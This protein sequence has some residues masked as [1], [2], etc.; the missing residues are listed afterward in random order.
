LAPFTIQSNLDCRL[1]KV[2]SFAVIECDGGLAPTTNCLLPLLLLLGRHQVDLVQTV[3]HPLLVL[4][5]KP[6]STPHSSRSSEPSLSMQTL[7]FRFILIFTFLSSSLLSSP[8]IIIII[9]F[10]F[11]Q[12][13]S[14]RQ[15]LH[16]S[17]WRSSFTLFVLQQQSSA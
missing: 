10:C 14:L 12:K 11:A 7:D 13:G 1:L 8:L 6:R 15:S 17:I 3:R 5:I 2:V 9:I 16:L 4:P